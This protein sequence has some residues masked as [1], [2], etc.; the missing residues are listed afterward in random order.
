MMVR[1]RRDNDK[2]LSIEAIMFTLKGL[3]FA[4]KI[5]I[6][7]LDKKITFKENISSYVHLTE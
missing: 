1:T 3:G 6:D 2:L 7:G 5:L 4:I